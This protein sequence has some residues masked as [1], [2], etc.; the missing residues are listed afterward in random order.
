MGRWWGTGAAI[1]ALEHQRNHARVATGAYR[2]GTVLPFATNKE[3]VII[4]VDDRGE[5]DAG[6]F[7]SGTA[8]QVPQ[9]L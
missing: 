6:F 8:C 5:T 1:Q 9:I 2:V 7:P 3:R 4:E